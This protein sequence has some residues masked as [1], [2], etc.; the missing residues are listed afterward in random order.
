M[1]RLVLV[2]D[3]SADVPPA[4]AAE[5]GIVI[6]PATYAFAD[7]AQPDG[8]VAAADFYGRMANEPAPP[9][10]F[11]VPEASFRAEFERIFGRGEEPFCVVAPF[12]VN[13]SF[14][15]AAAAM[16]S[17]E[18]GGPMKVVN[19]G[20]AS[21]GLCSLL[22]T[23]GR[24]LGRGWERQRALDAIDELAPQ[25]DSIFVPGSTEWLERAGRLA[26]VE[27]KLGEVEEGVPVLRVGTRITGV[28]LEASAEAALSRAVKTAGQRAG[29]RPVVVTIDHA[30]APA[31]AQ[32]AER[33]AREHLAVARLL[34]TELSVTFGSQL[35]PGAVGIG[36]APALEEAD[37]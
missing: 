6:V 28:A 27:E 2:T 22:V 31:V 25:C 29:G 5:A 33:L 4:V 17:L 10:P 24:G 14:T 3:S 13:P 20:V 16:L 23:L 35:G 32:V 7:H 15:T 30:C 12:D 18:H 36:V 26:L 37:A 11:G 21:A 1:P 19:P 8:S 34:V 9:R